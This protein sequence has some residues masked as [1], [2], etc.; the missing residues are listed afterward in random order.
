MSIII[1]TGSFAMVRMKSANGGPKE[2]KVHPKNSITV[3][4]STVSS[5]AEHLYNVNSVEMTKLCE[6]QDR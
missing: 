1:F 3:I 5:E 6:K 4:V 2:R